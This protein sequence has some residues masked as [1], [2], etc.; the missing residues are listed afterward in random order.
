MDDTKSAF[1]I[2]ITALITTLPRYIKPDEFHSEFRFK[3]EM[4]LKRDDVFISLVEHA[5][6]LGNC[7]SD[8]RGHGDKFDNVILKICQRLFTSH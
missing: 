8:I 5:Q 1:S 6:F 2:L 3:K 4:N 7:T